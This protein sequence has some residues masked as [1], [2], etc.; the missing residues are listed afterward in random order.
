M[1]TEPTLDRLR[2]LHLER[3]GRR[4][5]RRSTRTR[6]SAA[7][8][9]DERFGLLVDAEHLSRDNRELDPAPE[10]GQAPPA[11]RPVSRTSTTRRAASSIGR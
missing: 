8:G 1:M 11:R 2:A 6:R 9:F 5:S 7:L 4:L 3:D 10:G